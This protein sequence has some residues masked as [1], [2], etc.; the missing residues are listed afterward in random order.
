MGSTFQEIGVALGI[1]GLGAL[2]QHRM[3][4]AASGAQGADSS[5]TAL[6]SPESAQGPQA[7][8]S[9]AVRETFVEA[10]DETFLV[11]GITALAGAVVVLLL[12]RR[13]DAAQHAGQPDPKGI[14][15]LS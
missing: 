7:A 5:D 11:A 13:T 1:A 15:S 2:F 4:S 12:V 3:L 8:L 6:L 10:M 14:S 9:T